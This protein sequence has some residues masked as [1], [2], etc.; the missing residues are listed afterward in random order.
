[1]TSAYHCGNCPFSVSPQLGIIACENNPLG[2]Y[3]VLTKGEMNAHYEMG[4]L[5]HPLAQA[6]LREEGA[7]QERGRVLTEM[8][9]NCWGEYQMN[10][11]RCIICQIGDRCY[12]KR[13]SLRGQHGKK[14]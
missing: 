13:E 11:R 12:D 9:L 7:K 10:N 6:A 14:D 1:M 3:R 4:C 2:E 5:S 8:G